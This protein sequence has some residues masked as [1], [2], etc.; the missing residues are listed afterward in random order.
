MGQ[1]AHPQGQVTYV[2]MDG[3]LPILINENH[4]SNQ[5]HSKGL[6]STGFI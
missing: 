2:V 1:F 4:I 3:M 5:S 6:V